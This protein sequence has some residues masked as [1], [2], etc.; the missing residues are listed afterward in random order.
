MRI[1]DWSSDVCSSDL[2]FATVLEQAVCSGQDSILVGGQIEN[3]VGNDNVEAIPFEPALVESLDV[4]L[5]EPDIVETEDVG[6]MVSI[7]FRDGELLASHIDPNDF[8]GL[9]DE[10]SQQIGRAPVCSS[11]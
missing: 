5:D 2:E 8:A 3:A 6:V 10:L 11:H 7:R 9:T 4:A 1:S